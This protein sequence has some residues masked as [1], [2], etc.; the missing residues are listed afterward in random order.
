MEILIL[1]ARIII[2]ILEGVSSSRATRMVADESG[3]SFAELWGKLP[4]RYK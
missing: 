2:L 4:S 1:I 3:V